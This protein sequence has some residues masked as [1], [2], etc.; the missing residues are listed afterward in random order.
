[1]SLP[2][3]VQAPSDFVDRH[4]ERID[5]WKNLV[6]T[7][8]RRAVRVLTLS[9]VNSE[10]IEGDTP[11][12]TQYVIAQL[13]IVSK[14]AKGDHWKALV[15]AGVIG[16]LCK[17]ALNF[18]AAVMLR[19]DTGVPR[20]EVEN[21]AKQMFASYFHPLEIICNAVVS[22]SLPPTAT[23][24]KIV[25]EMKKYWSSIMQRVWSEPGYT[26]E[27]TPREVRVIERVVIAQILVRLSLFDP[28]FYEIILKPSDLTLA[29]LFRYWMHSTAV[30]DSRLNLMVL[31]PLLEPPYPQHL[32]EYFEQHPPPDMHALLPRIL[33]G[34][35]KTAGSEKKK[36]TPGQAADA[37]LSATASHLEKLGLEE[38]TYEYN[39]F[40]ALLNHS[41]KENRAFVRAAFK[42][43]SLWA[44]NAQ[45]M[46]RSAA[47]KSQ[48][49]DGVYMGALMTYS[50]VIHVVEQDGKEFIDAL[51]SSWMSTGL[52]DAVEDTVDVLMKAPRGPMLLTSIIAALDR[53]IPQLS[54]KT[55]RLMRSQLPRPRL[56]KS[57]LAPGFIRGEEDRERLD[58]DYADLV[59]R[60]MGSSPQNSMWTQ[61]AWQMLEQVSSKV[62]EPGD[63]ARRGCEKKVDAEGRP[64]QACH[65]CKITK[66]CS[67]GCL[68][69]D[70]AEHGHICGWVHF[71]EDI[72]KQTATKEESAPASE[73]EV[74]RQ[75]G[76]LTLSDLD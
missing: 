32:K 2:Y 54:A 24:K 1:M 18:Q 71:L 29:V 51:V 3:S 59:A 39:F 58:N 52:F 17:C 9:G 35:S 15:N 11:V 25:E 16:A 45:V 34:A 55:R 5:Q 44:A 49:G 36:R 31:L 10:T 23:E 37:I 12:D 60:G 65:M 7:D 56:I 43:S 4:P 13:R 61:G 72:R 70:M 50:T 40:H 64:E 42:S 68:E 75:L 22:G 69:K 57:L 8:P 19:E 67:I 62:E 30:A 66:Y 26:L 21:V 27:P 47:A 73:G 48:L 46:R 53:W 33:L 14:E 41:E 63:C 6:R 28:S 74:S 76:G 20:A 38:V